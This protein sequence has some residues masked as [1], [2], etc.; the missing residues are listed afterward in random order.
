MQEKRKR[1]SDMT[2]AE[3]Y[4]QQQLCIGQTHSVTSAQ[5]TLE[6]ALAV[7]AVRSKKVL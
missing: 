7:I 1:M 5:L 3:A 2:K 6:L 4:I